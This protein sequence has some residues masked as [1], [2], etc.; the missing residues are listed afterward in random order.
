M[1]APDR[2]GWLLIDK[3]FSGN[4]QPGCD[5]DYSKLCAFQQTL[6]QQTTANRSKLLTGR[7]KLYIEFNASKQT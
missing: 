3:L 6:T 4:C 1:V 7:V 5:N 2:Q